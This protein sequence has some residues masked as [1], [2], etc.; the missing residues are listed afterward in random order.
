ML[1]PEFTIKTLFYDF[2]I[3]LFLEMMFLRIPRGRIYL[4]SEKSFPHPI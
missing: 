4:F 3:V 1:N 2:L